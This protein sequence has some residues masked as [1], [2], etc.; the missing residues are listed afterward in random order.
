MAAEKNVF[1]LACP[2]FVLLQP[3]LMEVFTVG[4]CEGVS[5]SLGGRGGSEH[6]A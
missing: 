6:V 2:T 5:C 3:D 4:G 1:E